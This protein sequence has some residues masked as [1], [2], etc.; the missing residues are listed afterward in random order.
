MLLVYFLYESLSEILK[1][2]SD[3]SERGVCDRPEKHNVVL[4]KYYKIKA[5]MQIKRELHTATCKTI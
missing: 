4:M 3:L 5:N 1:A 2:I